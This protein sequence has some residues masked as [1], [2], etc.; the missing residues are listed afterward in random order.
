M[1]RAATEPGARAKYF[2]H[3]V[4]ATLSCHLDLE[5]P[6]HPQVLNRLLELLH[7]LVFEGRV[8]RVLVGEHAQREVVRRAAPE[9]SF[10]VALRVLAL[11]VVCVTFRVENKL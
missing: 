7:E 4:H 10:D 1:R 5:D 6:L 2:I 11:I 8:R 9:G 3:D